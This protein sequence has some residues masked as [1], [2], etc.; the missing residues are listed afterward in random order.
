M[1]NQHHEYY[2]ACPIITNNTV[3]LSTQLQP[4]QDKAYS[5]RPINY[6]MLYNNINSIDKGRGVHVPCA[7]VDIYDIPSTT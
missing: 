3:R 2:N 7:S 4:L 1:G 6:I 5:Q